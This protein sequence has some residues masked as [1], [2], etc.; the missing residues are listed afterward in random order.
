[1]NIWTKPIYIKM[2]VWVLLVLLIVLGI[3]VSSAVLYQN[4][5][6]HNLFFKT[7]SPDKIES[8]S[9]YSYYGKALTPLSNQ[10]TEDVIALLSNIRLKEAPYVDYGVTGDKGTDYRIK[11]KNG[12]QFDFNLSGGDPGV[13]IING[14]AYSVG[15]RDDPNASEDFENIWHLEELYRDH[16][17]KYYPNAK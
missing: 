2:R 5:V 14:K 4:Y 3:L 15:Y 12:I 13:Y 8:V 9:V 7:L 10:E 11:L 1:M 6:F 17:K 16:I